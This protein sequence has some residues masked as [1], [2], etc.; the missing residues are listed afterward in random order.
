MSR[1]TMSTSSRGTPRDYPVIVTAAVI[2]EGNED[3]VARRRHGP[4]PGKWEFP[5]GKLEPGEAPEECLRREIREELD[6][7][8]RVGGIVDVVYH[9]YD[10]GPV[11]L[12]AYRCT[13]ADRPLPRG[14]LPADTVRWVSPAELASL[15][16]APADVRIAETLR[17][18][19]VPVTR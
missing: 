7:E 16:L 10:T 12:L 9:R 14:S 6:L 8:V 15:D 1:I 17:S 18:C 4:L 2:R 3:L 11:L 13:L 19:S 5:E